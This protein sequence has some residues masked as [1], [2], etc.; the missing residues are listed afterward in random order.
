MVFIKAQN[1]SIKYFNVENL[2][3]IFNF[4]KQ[5]D[6]SAKTGFRYISSKDGSG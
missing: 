5:G 4:R 2:D 6:R 1:A 3:L